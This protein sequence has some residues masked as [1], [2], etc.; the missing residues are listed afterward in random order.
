M[1]NLPCWPSL[2]TPLK[3]QVIR[4]YSDVYDI[5]SIQNHFSKILEFVPINRLWPLETKRLAQSTEVPRKHRLLWYSFVGHAPGNEIAG[6][7]QLAHENHGHLCAGTRLMAGVKCAQ[8]T[9][10]SAFA[11]VQNQFINCT[12]LLWVFRATKKGKGY[13]G[14]IPVHHSTS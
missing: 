14:N 10:V 4:T 3:G 2:K 8:L 13:V 1:K 11:V 12:A 9:A 6:A 7:V 5:D